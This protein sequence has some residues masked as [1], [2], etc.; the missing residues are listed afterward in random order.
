MTPGCPRR[1]RH[2]PV[3]RIFGMVCVGRVVHILCGGKSSVYTDFPKVDCRPVEMALSSLGTG[4]PDPH[5]CVIG[6]TAVQPFLAMET[7]GNEL[8]VLPMLMPPP[9]FERVAT[10]AQPHPTLTTLKGRALHTL[11]YR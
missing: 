2:H 10:P 8:P 9:P 4:L 5:L 1:A 11:P 6:Q 7:A 3:Q